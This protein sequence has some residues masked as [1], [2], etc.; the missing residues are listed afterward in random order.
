MDL[1]FSPSADGNF[2]VT[3]AT[4]ATLYSEG[5][6][7]WKPP[8]IYHSSCEM[9]VEYFPFDEQT[10]VMKFGSWTYDGFQVDLR[11]KDEVADLAVVDFGIDL[12]EFY[13][14]V[15]WDILSVPAQR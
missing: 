12:T 14:S 7:E 8:A 1:S 11:H 9:D 4:K 2:E 10:C 15:E 13:Q 3:L 6:V 5:L